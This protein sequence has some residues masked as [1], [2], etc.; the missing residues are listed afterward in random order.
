MRNAPTRF[1][2]WL[3]TG[4]MVVLVVACLPV[5]VALAFVG[6]VV[7][8]PLAALAV[9]GG[10]ICFGLALREAFRTGMAPQIN[11]KG[12]HLA[13]DVGIHPGHCWARFK[14]NEIELGADD[15]AQ[16]M[17]GP[18][19]TVDMPAAGSKVRQGDCL[20]RLRRKGR[21]LEIRSP[22]SG[23][24][25]ASNQK[26][27]DRPWLVNEQPFSEGWAV[28]LRGERPQEES[29]I[30]LFG[31][32]AQAWFRNEVDRLIGCLLSDQAGLSSLVDGGTLVENLHSHIDDEA[33][34]RLTGPRQIPESK[35]GAEPVGAAL[36][37]ERQD[38]S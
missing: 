9:L 25:L 38:Q 5:V 8:L 28:R 26:L 7:L 19:E 3:R 15:V 2:E 14:P 37:A 1:K 33:W 30:L 16:T 36:S 20:F 35:S 22:V 21:S 17:L 27:Q 23:T 31:S 34:Q 32:K 29:G 12:L 11:Y 10:L 18:V 6:R 24:V 13:G 4:A